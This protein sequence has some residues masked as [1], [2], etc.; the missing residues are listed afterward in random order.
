MKKCFSNTGISGDKLLRDTGR[1]CTS[2]EH[3][4]HN[5]VNYWLVLMG[6]GLPNFILNNEWL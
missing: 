5:S 2:Y 6:K 4:Y 3:I 1:R